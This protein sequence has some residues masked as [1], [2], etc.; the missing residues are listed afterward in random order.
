MNKLSVE[1]SHLNLYNIL[2]ECHHRPRPAAAA[3]A[4]QVGGDER[5]A[6]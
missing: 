6:D 4:A 3:A 5:G 2:E 1:V